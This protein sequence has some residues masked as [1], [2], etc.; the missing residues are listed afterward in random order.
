MRFTLNI[1]IGNDAMNEFGAIQTAVQEAAA[2]IIHVGMS[3]QGEQVIR[4][5]NGNRVGTWGFY[6]ENGHACYF[7]CEDC[8]ED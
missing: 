3:A 2:K 1:E 8:D 5:V 6:D 7:E 4:D